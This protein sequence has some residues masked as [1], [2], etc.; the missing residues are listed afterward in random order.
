MPDIKQILPGLARF[1]IPFPRD[2]RRVVNS[3]VL[4]AGR[5]A[6]LIDAAWDVPEAFEALEA[7]LALGGL[8]PKDVRTVLITHLH[9]DHLGLAGRLSKLGAKIGY[10]PAEEMVMLPRLRRLKQFRGHT[11]LWERL[12]GAP[13]DNDPAITS[14]SVVEATLQDV[15]H[16]DLPLEG[17]ETIY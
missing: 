3:F 17:G 7:T 4:T 6:V 11:L 5:D 8:G 12:N 13:P 10:H 14:L 9:P 15:P 1:T 16:P 2:P